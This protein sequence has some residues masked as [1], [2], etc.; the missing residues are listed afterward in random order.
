MSP[1]LSTSDPETRQIYAR[2]PPSIWSAL[3]IEQQRVLFTA[4]RGKPNNH[5]FPSAPVF[6]Y[7]VGV[8][9]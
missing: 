9:I 7:P 6:E 3:N 8:I 5:L 1:E 4:I 2:I